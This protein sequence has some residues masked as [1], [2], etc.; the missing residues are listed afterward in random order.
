M[1]HTRLK[2]C[3][4][5]GGEG[6]R[7]TAGVLENMRPARR[8]SLPLPGVEY[9]ACFSFRNNLR[10]FSLSDSSSSA[11][12]VTEMRPECTGSAE[13][14]RRTRT[15][16]SSNKNAFYCAFWCPRAPLRITYPP[17]A[18][19]STVSPERPLACTAFRESFACVWCRREKLEKVEEA[20]VVLRVEYRISVTF[21]D[22]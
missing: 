22:P 10:S 2:S 14:R 4:M 11:R 5:V 7:N 1:L 9:C 12:P 17:A 21:L 20:L 18:A 19:S 16:R 13:R 8:S 6:G 3:R 15:F